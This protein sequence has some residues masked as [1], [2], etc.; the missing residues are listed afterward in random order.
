MKRTHVW[1]LGALFGAAS[2][3]I[4]LLPLWWVAIGQRILYPFP[5]DYGEGPLLRQ[6]AYL[7]QG[8]TLAGLYGDPGAP[9]YLI[10]NYP[11]VYL[12]V[13]QALGWGLPAL[14]AGRI[15][16]ALAG[17]AVALSI[18]RLVVQPSPP[19]YGRVF[20]LCTTLTWFALPIVREW[21]GVMRVDMLGVALGLAGLVAV[22]HKRPL[23]GTALVVLALLTKP[24]LLAAPLAL[25]V[26]M[27]SQPWRQWVRMA[28]VALA[29]V[30]IV[31]GGITLA[32]GNIWLHVIQANVNLWDEALARGFWR[33]AWQ[34]HWPLMIAALLI[35]LS[36][37]IRS[38][39][40]LT[41]PTTIWTSMAIAYTVG[42][43][44]VGLGI[45][46]VGAYANYFLEWYA[47]MVWI[48]GI[49]AQ[50]ALAHTTWRRWLAVGCVL[51]GSLAVARYIP[52]W[53]ETYP[54][55]YGMI[56]G[57]R[58][59]RLIVGGY[60]VWQD[61]QR[62]RQILDA[63][64]V[65][66][67][68]LN[69][70]I[71][72]L[73]GPVFTDVP[74]VAA[75][76]GVEAPMQVFEH[77]Q[78][79][80]V[81][82]WDQ[83]PMLRML[84]NGEMPLVVL[85]YLGNW[86]TPESIALIQTR[87]AQSGSRGSFDLYQPI[88]VGAPQPLQFSWGALQLTQIALPPPLLRSAYEPGAIVP[89]QLTFAG[90]DTG[91]RHTVTLTLADEKERVVARSVHAL[92]AG[93]LQTSDLAAGPLQ[94]MQALPISARTADGVYRL[95]M[96]LDDMPKQTLSD[97]VVQRAGGSMAGE[98]GYLVPGAINDYTQQN[99][100]TAAWGEP[101]MPAMPFN[102]M[103]LQ[104]FSKRCA[105]VD[106]SGIVSTAPIGVWLQGA[107]AVWPQADRMDTYDFTRQSAQQGDF[108]SD[109]YASVDQPRATAERLVWLRRDVEL[110]YVD[111]QVVVGDGGTRLM[112][113]PGIPYRWPPDHP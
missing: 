109:A 40:Q 5:I 112:R 54:K 75:Q 27:I 94:H 69:A 93:A 81:G 35:T 103:T 97:I 88:A 23:L 95:D 32:G 100:G 17:V 65:T 106:T 70:E 4:G 9:P 56:E 20:A 14:M 85:D 58:P 36:V 16:S 7:Q 76:A 108:E 53:S 90:G 11:P 79:L 83:R 92:F 28:A 111:D 82:L 49:G 67:A 2:L 45:G 39:R 84:A 77:R 44:I 55:P 43:I 19:A 10:V 22:R 34:L 96:Q 33:E 91:Q 3:V 78:L 15:V 87:Y 12:L 46:K 1:W 98:G 6:L 63:N 68:A 21:S 52:L 42:G 37:V 101:L 8:G 74:G 13:S 104:C 57:Q 66:A 47:G 89:V 41:H 29:V 26:W 51:A 61:V 105:M 64:A 110:W 31:A 99:G 73:G 72:A 113:L 38:W 71:A 107:L 24:S 25:A 62:E 102:D 50:S 86:M 48:L 59:P 30:G 18:W 80:D 60:G